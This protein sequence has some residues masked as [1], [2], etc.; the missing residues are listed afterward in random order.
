MKPMGWRHWLLVLAFLAVVGFTG[1]QAMRTAE[2]VAY[3]RQHRDDP[4]RPW[5]SLGYVAH[6]YHV[7][8]HVLY[9][10]LGLPFEPRDRRPIARL[11]KEQRRADKDLIATLETAIAH[12]RPPNPA[13]APPV[14]PRPND[15]RVP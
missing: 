3:W 9:E 11:A 1:S 12:A 4:I 7:P 6:S 8:P 2:L 10:A 5:M 14:A 15:G 13:P